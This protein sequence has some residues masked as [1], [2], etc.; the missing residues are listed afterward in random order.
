MDCESTLMTA[1]Q[2]TTEA[3]AALQLGNKIEAIKITREAT[4]LGLKEA[5]ELVERYVDEH[6][7]LKAQMAQ[8]NS[9]GSFFGWLFMIVVAIAAI[10]YF[11]PRG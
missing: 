10:V 4:N 2:L 3:I 8:N 6:P 5:K 11:W 7:E 9:A 1:T